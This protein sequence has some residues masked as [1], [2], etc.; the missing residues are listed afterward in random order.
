MKKWIVLV[1]LVAIGTG[2]YVFYGKYKR[3]SDIAKEHQERDHL[4]DPLCRVERP[5]GEVQEHRLVVVEG[6]VR[7]RQVAEDD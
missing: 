4:V 5:V 7:P 2:G 1:L 6:S 3:G